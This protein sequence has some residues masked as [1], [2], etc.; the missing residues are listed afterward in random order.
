[1]I[2]STGLPVEGFIVEIQNALCASNNLVLVAAP[3]AGK[4][5]VVPLHLFDE[6]WMQGK[7]TLML[8][9][10]RIAT[11]AAARRLAALHGSTLGQTVGFQIRFDRCIG[12]HTRIEVL[13]EG[14]LTRR[15]QQDPFLEDVGLVIFDEFHERSLHADLGL[16]LCREVQQTVRPDLRLLMMSATIEAGPI[17][18]FLGQCPTLQIPGRQYP[19]ETL[20]LER[21]STLSLIERVAQAVERLFPAVPDQGDLLVFL[22]GEAEI[23]RVKELLETRGFDRQ[24]AILPLHGT[25]PVDRQDEVLRPGTRRRIIL[26]TNVA[27]TSLTIEGVRGVLDSGLARQVRLDPRTGLERLETTT[28][29]LANARQRT[30]RAGRLGPGI[31]LR[32]WTADEERSMPNEIVPEIR[33]VDLAHL[34]LE[35]A[36]WGKPDPLKLDWLEAPPVPAVGAARQ[37]L[38]QLGA[39]T[40]DGGVTVLGRRMA[41]LPLHP[42]IA[43]LLLFAEQLGQGNLGADIAALL[44]ERDILEGGR[45]E[46]RE[47]SRSDLFIRL[48]ALDSARRQHFRGS[49]SQID[50]RA[51]A[52]VDRVAEQ[53]RRYLTSV[54]AEQKRK[55]VPFEEAVGRIPLPA[56]PDRIARRR[57]KPVPGTRTGYVLADGRGMRL[58]ESSSVQQSEFVIALAVDG[59]E[60]GE[61]REGLIHLAGE[62]DPAW[63]R[64]LLSADITT[65]REPVFDPQRR[66]FSIR[67][68]V[69]YRDLLLDESTENMTADDRNLVEQQLAE[70]A[71]KRLNEALTFDE[72]FEQLRFRLRLLAHHDSS[73]AIPEIDEDWIRTRL[74][75]LVM[76]KRSFADLKA[77][78]LCEF[79][80]AQLDH[81][82]VGSLQRHVPE[83]FLLPSGRKVRLQYQLDGPPVLAVKLQELFGQTETPKLMQGRVSVLIHLLS[84]A[85]R[86]LQITQDLRNFW[87]TVYPGLQR[88]M[89]A[90]Y[91]KHSWPDDPFTSRPPPLKR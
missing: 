78:S 39:I 21:P 55:A 37:L 90:K 58:S 26:A 44:S 73:L 64:E 72:E 76:G 35:L 42:R 10:R 2:R 59:T 91:P 8:E 48:E 33:R 89:R 9:P 68:R 50:L 25:L 17:A 45:R 11:R 12:P 85:G 15:L 5:T 79:T 16:A 70:E 30:G 77:V 80:L 19:V 51:A 27:E 41:A 22:P 18:A 14:L 49:L 87:L 69:F 65:V 54:P 67:R 74:P 7:R 46:A 71:G 34:A 3:G 81:R 56:F 4:T 53:L 40:S 75:G 61:T 52:A 84:P 57:G 83:R 23:Y 36:A 38:Q 62:I 60:R 43:R 1:M 47:S 6:P 88:Q 86:P 32:L 82:I 20:H 66:S 63:I 13:T 29:S 28:I 24:A 31:C